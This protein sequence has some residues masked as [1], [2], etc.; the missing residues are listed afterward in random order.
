MA[1]CVESLAQGI[2]CGQGK[3]N[4][5]TLSCLLVQITAILPEETY[6]EGKFGSKYLDYNASQTSRL[7]A[8]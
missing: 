4:P 7:L 6:L 1:E 3:L 2:V 8:G 5:T